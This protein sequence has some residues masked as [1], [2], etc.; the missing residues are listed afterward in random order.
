MMD[1]P[2]WLWII[3]PLPTLLLIGAW[4]LDRIIDRRRRRALSAEYERRAVE[5][6]RQRHQLLLDLQFELRSRQLRERL[7]RHA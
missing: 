2:A 7:A 3:L 5:R 1:L 6:A 4:L